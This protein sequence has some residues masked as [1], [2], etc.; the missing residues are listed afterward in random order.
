MRVLVF[1]L[2]I[3]PLIAVAQERPRA[4][5]VLDASGSMW[6]QIDGQAKITIAQDVVGNLLSSLPVEQEL[7]LTVYGHRRKGDC[8]DI[9]T[10]VFP[11]GNTR[12]LI[13][14]AVD[15]IKPKGKTPLSAAVVAAAEELR[16]TEEKATVI[17][18]SDGRETCEVDP[19]EVGRQLEESGVD[20]TAH[21]IGF[22]VAA[23]EDRAE[24]QCL[25][26]NTGGVFRT[27]SNAEELTKA[28]EVVAEPPAPSPVE[29]TFRA[30]EGA[31]GSVIGYDL[32]WSLA[33]EAVSVDARQG[34]GFAMA[35]MPGIY[36]VD[37]LRPRDEIYVEAEIVVGSEDQTVTLV[38]PEL[39]P[40]PVT[41][42]VMARVENTT[43]MVNRDIEWRLMDADGGP[44]VEAEVAQRLVRDLPRGEYLARATRVIDGAQ[45]E[46]RFGVGRSEKVV[47][48]ELPE[49]RPAATLEADGSAPVGSDLAVRWTGPDA[50][51]DFIAIAKVGASSRNY[52][53]YEY[54]REGPYLTVK[55]PAEPGAYEVRYILADGR[56]ILASA[57]VEALP[58]EAALD[59]A[60]TAAAGSQLEIT[61]DG[62]NYKGDYIAIV[63]EG[64][65]EGSWLNYSYTSDGSPL[66]L[67][68]PVEPGAYE[69]RY[70]MDQKDTTLAR[71]A[72]EVTALGTTLTAP[73]S[74]R[75]GETI[76]VDWTGGGYNN[77]YIAFARPEDR[78]GSYI[79]YGYVN[80]GSPA[81]V[82]A[83]LEPGTYELR[84]VFNQ[85]DKTGASRLIEILPV[86]VSLNAPA[87]AAAGATI[88]VDW[89]GPD[90]D[91]DY[92]S[93]A[94]AGSR[95]SDYVN[96]SYTRHGSAAEVELPVTPGQYELRYMANGSPDRALATRVIS[97]TPVSA[98]VSAPAQASA[99][100][101]ISVT[102]EG[103]AYARDYIGIG[104]VGSDRYQTYTYTRDGS[105]LEINVPETAGDYEV[106]YFLGQ[107]DTPLAR[108]PLKVVP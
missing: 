65:R 36:Q 76:K 78:E 26:E 102:W 22:D 43:K 100:Q 7:G 9:E 30:S 90:Y 42:T 69:I 46:V 73:D 17:L 45:G 24:L 61:W 106:L 105:P 35:L 54:T 89:T 14:E 58:A 50:E 107:G 23:E 39:P 21:V 27:A 82:V 44:I 5:L 15:G 19:C 63:A 77:D 52:E 72:I 1:L 10:L 55:M 104:L 8:T 94:A 40:P 103:P 67:E 71:R 29:V 13:R 86:E 93:V 25:A 60:A 53:T 4:I 99:G 6:G 62:P 16:Y 12:D 96:Y 79:T 38:F 74:A 41:V 108:V 84:Y 66:K 64:A 91:N 98:S 28:L 3:L 87:E 11:G 20:F 80:N 49:Y 75:I 48:L 51:N 70:V 47:W 83:P 57:P 68:M 33:G 95:E 34:A 101:R 59:T 2:S 85:G 18:V 32:I 81:E 97:V 31:G 88:K 92:L 56:S 37:A